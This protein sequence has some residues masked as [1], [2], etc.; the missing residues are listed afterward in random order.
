MTK[1]VLF[2][3]CIMFFIVYSNIS[4]TANNNEA[5]IMGLQFPNSYDFKIYSNTVEKKVVGYKAH[6]SFPSQDV[7]DFYD[8][9]LKNIGWTSFVDP[10]L[11]QG[12]RGWIDFVDNT[13]QGQPLVHQL[14][15]HW[16]N[17]DH[18]RMVFMV[19]RYYSKNI[20][21]EKMRATKPNN[22][23]QEVMLQIMPFMILQSP[24]TS[25]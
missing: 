9:K 2:L 8:K 14:H 19:I 24:G 15:A 6:L 16:V 20:K 1:K 10:D 4:W 21:I 12:D 5:Y 22:D 11:R 7:V 3:I 17:N 18:T 13:V 23:I 25:K